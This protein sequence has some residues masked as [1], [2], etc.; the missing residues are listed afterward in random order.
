MAIQIT[1]DMHP[2]PLGTVIHCLQERVKEGDD[3]LPKGWSGRVVQGFRQSEDCW[4]YL[5][6]NEI[7]EEQKEILSAFLEERGELDNPEKF[8]MLVA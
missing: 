3:N 2:L 6:E 8:V 7:S 5:V 4:C 1:A